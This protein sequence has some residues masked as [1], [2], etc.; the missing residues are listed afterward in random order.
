MDKTIYIVTTRS[1]N[2]EANQR[3]LFNRENCSPVNFN[4]DGDWYKIAFPHYFTDI[5]QFADMRVVEKLIRTKAN[6]SFRDRLDNIEEI[7]KEEINKEIEK[8]EEEGKI[9]IVLKILNTILLILK[10]AKGGFS[11][12]SS[13]KDKAVNIDNDK[14]DYD[15]LY[16]MMKNA[17]NEVAPIIFEETWDLLYA[18]DNEDIEKVVGM[19]VE[20]KSFKWKYKGL[21]SSVTT[22]ID[23]VIN[24]VLKRIVTESIPIWWH[25]Q[26]YLKNKCLYWESEDAKACYDFLKG[27][28]VFRKAESLHSQEV[29]NQFSLEQPIYQYNID[30][31]NEKWFIVQCFDMRTDPDF[32]LDYLLSLIEE[33]EDKLDK[34]YKYKYNILIHDYDIG[35]KLIR[36]SVLLQKKEFKFVLDNIKKSLAEKELEIIVKGKKELSPSISNADD[37]FSNK[38]VFQ[39]K[40]D[41]SILQSDNFDIYRELIKIRIPNRKTYF[42]K[43]ENIIVF[44][45]NKG[46]IAKILKKGEI[47]PL[48][49]LFEYRQLI[50]ELRV[51]MMI[52]IEKMIY[53]KLDIAKLNEKL[54]LF[55]IS[56]RN[57]LSDLNKQKGN[58]SSLSVEKEFLTK[59]LQVLDNYFLIT[60]KEG[61][62]IEKK[63]SIPVELI[64]DI[65]SI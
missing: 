25:R 60:K 36:S 17:I 35:R 9:N 10:T 65:N 30:T 43:I 19:V 8:R 61:T 62:D 20:N 31:E 50:M 2:C 40:L 6:R 37:F 24:N 44:K 48:R 5:I 11:F 32:G 41:F 49:R 55:H 4:K 51:Q 15:K 23:T 64:K 21:Q 45:H 38:T 42:G 3:T 52:D 39:P 7:T 27:K 56:V 34:T 29:K 58:D 28:D 13:S 26:I 18:L 57:A 47:Q 59:M 54:R 12:E 1:F 16:P 14:I 63:I 53:G 46:E 33:V 22:V